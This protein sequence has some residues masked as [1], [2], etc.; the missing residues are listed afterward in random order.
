MNYNWT[1]WNN[2]VAAAEE[3]NL[4]LRSKDGGCVYMAVPEEIRKKFYVMCWTPLNKLSSIVVRSDRK[5]PLDTFNVKNLLDDL[6][7]NHGD[8]HLEF[9]AKS[10]EDGS[11]FWFPNL[12]IGFSPSK[13]EIVDAV[14]IMMDTENFEKYKLM[15]RLREA[16]E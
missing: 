9:G 2:F 15:A 1:L 13:D 3:L 4:E 6:K 14:K 10:Y 12:G 8:F 11:M 7:Q 16:T 5:T